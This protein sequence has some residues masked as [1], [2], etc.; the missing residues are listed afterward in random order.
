M[1]R[2][3]QKF[4]KWSEQPVNGLK[5]PIYA[6]SKEQVVFWGR[7]TPHFAQKPH[8]SI[9]FSYNV[10]PS[11]DRKCSKLPKKDQRGSKVAKKGQK[12]GKNRYIMNRWSLRLGWPLISIRNMFLLM[13]HIFHTC[14]ITGSAKKCP[15]RVKRDHMGSKGR[16]KG[17]KGPKIYIWRTAGCKN[18][19][20]SSF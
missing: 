11:G 13:F 5:V 2:K 17:S 3:P 19:V 1:L 15:N 9:C 12:G 6:I 18:L 20:D 16:K 8:V 7:L 10:Y 4:E 14:Q